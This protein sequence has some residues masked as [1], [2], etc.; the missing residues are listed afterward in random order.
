[1][2][3]WCAQG[4][5]TGREKFIFGSVMMPIDARFD[6]IES[7]LTIQWALVF[8]FAPPAFFV[9]IPGIIFFQEVDGK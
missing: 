4:Q 9:P 6:E 2:R 5:Y 7:A 3:Y 1:M 8:P